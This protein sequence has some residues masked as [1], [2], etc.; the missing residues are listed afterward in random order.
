[1]S[2]ATVIRKLQRV[3]ALRRRAT[4]PGERAAAETVC[5][6][7]IARLGGHETPDWSVW[8]IEPSE[9]EGP[10]PIFA[11]SGLE[12]PGR[13]QILAV[14][15]AWSTGHYAD[16]EVA[17][18]AAGFTYKVWLPEHPPDDVRSIYVEVILQLSALHVQPLTRDDVPALRLFVTAAAGDARDAWRIWWT[19]LESIDWSTRRPFTER[20]GFDDE[21]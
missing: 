6:R 16:E 5:A 4:T 2:R 15:L 10:D 1:M 3:D 14:L 13:D 8:S 12:L 19:H 11:D 7:L 9:P 20:A 21:D 17:E 18:W